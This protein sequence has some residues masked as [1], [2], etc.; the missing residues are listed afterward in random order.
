[1]LYLSK[2]LSQLQLVNPPSRKIVPEFVPHNGQLILGEARGFQGTPV[3]S[4]Q[5]CVARNGEREKKKGITGLVFV[6][7]IF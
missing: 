1:M 5:N 3:F 4:R 7:R 2:Y 6:V